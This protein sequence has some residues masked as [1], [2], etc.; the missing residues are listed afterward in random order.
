MSM[1]FTGVDYDECA[2][3]RADSDNTYA[4]VATRFTISSHCPCGAFIDGDSFGPG[5]RQINGRAIK[6]GETQPGTSVLDLLVELVFCTGVLSWLGPNPVTQNFYNL[7]LLNLRRHS[8]GEAFQ[9]K[10]GMIS[11]KQDGGACLS[12]CTGGLFHSAKRA[13]ENHLS[14][15]ACA[16]QPGNCRSKPCT[17]FWRISA[18]RVHVAMT[19]WRDWPFWK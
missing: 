9:A 1:T 17:S 11:R 4:A 10:L 2:V 3:N 8:P 6:E 19:S 5:K 18:Y 12:R 13:G 16:R 7:V 14:P 15:S